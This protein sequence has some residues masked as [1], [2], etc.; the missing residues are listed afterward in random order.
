MSKKNKGKMPLAY[1][2][3]KI[4]KEVCEEVEEITPQFFNIAKR[5][6]LTMRYNKGIGLAAPQVGVPIR[7]IVVNV[8]DGDLIMFNPKIVKFSSQQSIHNESCLS[9]PKVFGDVNRPDAVEV[10][11]T[12]ENNESQKVEAD[13]L[14]ARCI[15]HEVDHLNGI[16]FIDKMTHPVLDRDRRFLE[17][18]RKR[19]EHQNA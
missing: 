8:G 7:L 11:W 17:L 18:T 19:G 1:Y 14:F 13:G 16:L 15:Q 9:I 6:L 4:L 2:G 12:D 5:M 10:E 3:N